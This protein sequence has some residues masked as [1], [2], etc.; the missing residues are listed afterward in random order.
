VLG[1]PGGPTIIT[2]MFLAVQNLI[3]FNMNISEAVNECRYH[4]QDD[5]GNIHAEPFCF[6]KDTIHL[7]EERGYKIQSKGTYFG[8]SY[9][10]AMAGIAIEPQTNLK[11]GAMDVRRSGGSAEGF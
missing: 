6:S 7:L 8:Q 10:G 5:S 11:L 2:Q 4:S 9:W 1:T 3:D